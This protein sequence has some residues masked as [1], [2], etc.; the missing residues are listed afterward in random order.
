MLQTNSSGPATM[1]EPLR[2]FSQQL[3]IQTSPQHRGQMRFNYWERWCKSIRHLATVMNVDYR[4][5]FE[6]SK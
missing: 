3:P 4:T 5:T 1:T 6:P 2:C